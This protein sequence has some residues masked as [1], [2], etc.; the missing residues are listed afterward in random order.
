MRREAQRAVETG[1]AQLRRW[2]SRKYNLPANHPLFLS[3]TP[4]DLNQEMYEDLLLRRAELRDS[5]G[6]TDNA[7]KKK[8]LESI[9]AINVLFG[10]KA[11]VEDELADQWERDL[12]E[13]R[14]PDLDAR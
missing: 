5:L 12:A 13:G 11:E 7:G 10:E 1:R 14:D 3:R 2:W 9:S 6:D 8:I 4:S